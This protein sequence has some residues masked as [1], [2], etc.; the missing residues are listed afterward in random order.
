MRRSLFLLAIPAV[1]CASHCKQKKEEPAAPRSPG[2]DAGPESA[3]DE[4]LLPVKRD[5]KVVLV[6][7]NCD[8]V[9]KTG[10]TEAHDVREGVV[11]VKV[12]EKWGL[13]DMSGKMLVEPTYDHVG[14]F[15]DGF[16]VVKKGSTYGV[17]DGKWKEV[18]MDFKDNPRV[19]GKGR[20]AVQAGKEGGM[21][22]MG[23]FDLYDAQG[24][25][26]TKAGYHYIHAFSEDLALVELGN[27]NGYIDL[28]GDV[29]IPLVY[30]DAEPFSEGLAF[31][32]DDDFNAHFIDRKGNK[33]L[34]SKEWIMA[35][36][37]KDG[38]SWVDTVD[39]DGVIDRKGEYVVKPAFE[40]I[41]D[42]E[43]GLA[44]AQKE[45]R[46]G[47]INMKGQWVAEP[48]YSDVGWWSQ[49]RLAVMIDG[50][51]G[52]IDRTGIMVIQPVFFDASD[53]EKELALV[54][55]SDGSWYIDRQG[56]KVC[57][58]AS[59]D[60]AEI[61]ERLHALSAQV[62]PSPLPDVDADELK[63]AVESV[64]AAAKDMKLL[65]LSIF[66]GGVLAELEKDRLP[67]R[68]V[69]AM[70]SLSKAKPEQIPALVYS[71]LGKWHVKEWEATCP[72]GEALIDDLSLMDGE[73]RAGLV[74]E[75][76]KL[77]RLKLV[78]PAAASNAT[79]AFLALGAASYDFLQRNGTAS[80]E[81]AW[82]F[83]AFIT[84]SVSSKK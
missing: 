36:G 79:D 51:W 8:A 49:E 52:Y 30:D 72:G 1:L 13:M 77:H 54:L 26:L 22:E 32:R 24:R 21:M 4:T 56:S 39:G 28:L 18:S 50:K 80:K 64:K 44:S 58:A 66:A 33:V 68:Y 19:L 6:N 55:Q 45:K 47:V 73:K 5:G 65:E 53:F 9:V 43:K 57:L 76:C 34:S 25:R 71:A 74:F 20:F 16:A 2:S 78:E 46:W 3:G 62:P 14:S 48:R 81:E 83:R 84:G 17:I 23:T 67:E 75:K 40:R 27:K 12:G 15:N 69:R 42:I 38:L 29:V 70:E 11:A 82:L 10:A 35:G 60:E 41:K 7:K 63:Q 61:E 31:V 59:R 37:F